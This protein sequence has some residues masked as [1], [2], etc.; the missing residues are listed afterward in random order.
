MNY[1]FITGASRSGTTFMSR[2]LA[3]VPGA[4]V[5]HEYIP[6]QPGVA[7][8]E[9]QIVSW[10]LGDTYA[11]PYLNRKKREIESKFDTEW[12]VDVDCGIRHSVPAVQQVFPGAKIFHLVRDPRSVIRSQYTRRVDHLT[13]KLPHNREELEWW[14][15]ADKLA[16]IC[17]EWSVINDGLIALDLPVLRLEDL[18]SNFQYLKDRFLDPCGLTMSGSD[19]ETIR[20]TR[21]NKTRG[22]LYRYVYAKLKGKNYSSDRLPPFEHWA[23]DQKRTL[24]NICGETAGKLGYDLGSPD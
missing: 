20:N 18:T 14:L 16:Q 1:V 3:A 13:H 17:W 15:D 10:Y 8:R 5:E 24:V 12:F 11:I 21:V 4:A 6:S 19:W 2:L 23:S 9:Y 22:R 7:K